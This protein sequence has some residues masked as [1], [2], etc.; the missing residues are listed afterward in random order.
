MSKRLSPVTREMANVFPY[1][2]KVQNDEQSVGHRLLNSIA[3]PTEK[4]EKEIIRN[5]A[6]LHLT[7]A[8]LNEIDWIYRVDLGLDFEFSTNSLDPFNEVDEAP[9]ASGLLDGSY[10]Q[11][12]LAEKNNLE[13]FWYTHLPDRIS[14]GDIATGTYTILSSSDIEDAPFS[15]TVT[16]FIPNYLWVDC[17]GGEQYIRVDDEEIFRRPLVQITGKT[18]KGTLEQETIPFP[19]DMKQRTQKEWDTV[20]K[21]D[22]FDMPSGVLIDVVSADFNGSPYVD[23]WNISYSDQRK[24]ID[25]FWGVTSG[26]TSFLNYIKYSTDDVRQMLDGIF[27]LYTEIQFELLDES[28]NNINVLDIAQQPF[29]DWIWGLSASKLYVFD[30]YLTMIEDT[31]ALNEIDQDSRHEIVADF[32]HIARGDSV[33]VQFINPDQFYP[34]DRYRVWLDCPD[35]TQSG[36]LGGDTITFVTDDWNYTDSYRYQVDSP[37]V[38]EPNQLGE[39]FISFEVYL[40]DGSLLR[41]KRGFIIDLKVALKSFDLTTVSGLLGTPTGITFDSD[42]RLWVETT[43]GFFQ[44]NTHHDVMMIDFENKKIFLREPY[45][46][47]SVL[48]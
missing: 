37:F 18:R 27:S 24:K 48:P 2:S 26:S 6:N 39:Y 44:I 30:N 31:D 12:S 29:S 3:V 22:C 5:S 33:T 14:I 20:Y 8:N 42:Q 40:N 16:S 36:I 15:G 23:I 38:F 9:T 4:L 11:I 17:V 46:S 34:I 45:E 32:Y 41:Q 13:E 19:W 10:Y 7:T 21:V 35:G 1:W 28:S 43:S 47:I 25:T